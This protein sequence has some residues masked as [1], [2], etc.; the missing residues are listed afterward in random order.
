MIDK[1]N[2]IKHYLRD[3]EL[4]SPLA[5]DEQTLKIIQ[6]ATKFHIALFKNEA[7]ALRLLDLENVQESSQEHMNALCEVFDFLLNVEKNTQ[8]SK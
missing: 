1:K 7:L 8:L 5:K 6:N 4:H 3:K 2:I